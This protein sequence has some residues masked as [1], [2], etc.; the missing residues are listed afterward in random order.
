[1]NWL[2]AYRGKLYMYDNKDDDWQTAPR[3][4]WGTLA[5]GGNLVQVDGFEEMKVQLRGGPESVGDV[6]RF[7][8]NTNTCHEHSKANKGTKQLGSFHLL[9]HFTP[10][11][12]RTSSINPL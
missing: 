4:R 8:T 11:L 10:Y 12:A 1:M 2:C 6:T 9:N 3:I 7:R 5:L